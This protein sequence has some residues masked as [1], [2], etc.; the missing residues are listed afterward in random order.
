MRSRSIF[1]INHAF[2]T[3]F[4]ISRND[5]SPHVLNDFTVF[6]NF[7]SYLQCFE[8]YVNTKNTGS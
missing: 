3:W 6:L 7:V 5:V 8:E 2:L 4:D 1:Q